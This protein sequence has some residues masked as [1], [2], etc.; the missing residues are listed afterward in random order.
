MHAQGCTPVHACVHAAAEAV[1]S[2]P[3]RLL[4]GSRQP[5]GPGGQ[6]GRALPAWAGGPRPSRRRGGALSGSLAG[7]HDGPHLAPPH[8]PTSRSLPWYTWEDRA[9]MPR[10]RR[11]V[12]V[13]GGC[14]G[15]QHAQR[16]QA[17]SRTLPARPGSPLVLIAHGR[18]LVLQDL[19]VGDE[20]HHQHVAQRLGL[21]SAPAPGGGQWG[22]EHAP[23][24]AAQAQCP[25]RCPLATRP[26]AWA[27]RPASRQ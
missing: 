9:A 23:G 15:M 3:P 6:L 21:R 19:A 14:C 1:T 16:R 18:A 13:V 24:A 8:P 12:G 22:G 5:L 27:G 20:A 26:A 4:P 7:C 2:W 10:R 17:R 25:A 11:G